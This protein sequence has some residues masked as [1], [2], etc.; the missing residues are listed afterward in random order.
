M[1]VDRV[2]LDARD[3]RLGSRRPMH[4]QTPVLARFPLIR[5]NVLVLFP[6]IIIRGSA[7]VPY[8][9]LTMF[10]FTSCSSCQ[11][12]PQDS[13]QRDMINTHLQRRSG[14]WWDPGDTPRCTPYPE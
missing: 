9:E 13:H 4:L 8:T 3:G 12:Y 7:R 5:V 1:G 14:P 2:E 10:I 6:N 11:V